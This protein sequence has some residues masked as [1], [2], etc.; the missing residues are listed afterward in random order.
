LDQ[1]HRLHRASPEV[2]DWFAGYIGGAL[3]LPWDNSP[4]ADLKKW[5]MA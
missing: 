5:L 1:W 3:P 2:E 4:T